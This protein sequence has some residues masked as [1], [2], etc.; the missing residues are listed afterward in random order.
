MNILLFGV[1]NIGKTTIG[2]IVADK[3]GYDFYDLDEVIKRTYKVSM[4]GFI[5]K[6]WLR[7]TRDEIRGELLGEIIRSDG[8]KVVAVSPMYY[9]KYFS[10]YLK[11]GE[12]FGIE[13]QE[14]PE[15]IFERLIFTD[16]NDQ[17]Y[18]DCVEYREA[19]KKYYLKE[20]K[21]DRTFFKKSFSKIENK[22][23]MNNDSPEVAAERLIEQFDLQRRR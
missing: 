1:S 22:F 11:K 12:A 13:L 20:I 2:E 16:E 15:N 5:D 7:I 10:R 14:T 23:M 6:Y 17:L 8:D 19:H 21:K 4:Q 9:S 18:D 3:L